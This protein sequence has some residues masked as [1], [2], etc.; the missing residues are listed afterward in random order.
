QH[1]RVGR[2]RAD[3]GVVGQFHLDDGGGGGRAAGRLVL[4]LV[5]DVRLVGV[6][7]RVEAPEGGVEIAVHA[8]AADGDDEVESVVARALHG[9][10]HGRGLRAGRVAV[11][12][13]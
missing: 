5:E 2:G 8:A 7:R 9:G 13:A 11:V 12:G 4:D 1:R 10:V 3:D 6:A